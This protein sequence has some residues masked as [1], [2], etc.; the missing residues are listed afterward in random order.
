MEIFLTNQAI[1]G[2]G[3]KLDS[4]KENEEWHFFHT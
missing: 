3:V 4:N 2:F 1:W